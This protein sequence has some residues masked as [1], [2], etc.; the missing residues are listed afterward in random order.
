M[1]TIKLRTTHPMHADGRNH[2]AG[3][4]L[5][6]APLQAGLVLDS[7]RAELVNPDDHQAITAARQADN[8]RRHASDQRQASF[9]TFG[10][11]ATPR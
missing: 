4:E 10:R 5:Q 7:G 3:A 1:N 11:A 8:R 2:A 9:G 6:L